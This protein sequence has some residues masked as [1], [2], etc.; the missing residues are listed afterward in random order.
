MTLSPSLP[1]TLPRGRVHVA[2]LAHIKVDEVDAEADLSCSNYIPVSIH[3]YQLGKCGFDQEG[4]ISREL[5]ELLQLK[6]LLEKKKK[7]RA[8][9]FF[10]FYSISFTVLATESVHVCMHCR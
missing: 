10:Q 2:S 3:L 7:G 1:Q 9:K 4:L 5:G 6:T 8:C